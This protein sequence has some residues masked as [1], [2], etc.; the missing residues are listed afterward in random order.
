MPRAFKAAAMARSVVAP[1]TRICR[2]IGSTFA[3]K[4]SAEVRFAAAPFIWFCHVSR[5]LRRTARPDLLI[6]RFA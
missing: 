3:A 5:R 1:A 6:I 4:A 2:T